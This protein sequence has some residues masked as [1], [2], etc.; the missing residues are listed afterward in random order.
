MYSPAGAGSD[1]DKNIR[2][3]I[4]GFQL[5]ETA[6]K[7]TVTLGG[8]LILTS[9]SIVKELATHLLSLYNRGEIEAYNII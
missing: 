6:L 5:L 9:D 1:F 8:I 2:Q 4:P 3:A 7:S